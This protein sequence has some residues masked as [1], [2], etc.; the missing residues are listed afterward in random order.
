[1]FGCAAIAIFKRIATVSVNNSTEEWD[2]QTLAQK[3][4][5]ST[6][7]NITAEDVERMRQIALIKRHMDI[8]YGVMV[9]LLSVAGF[10]FV[11][12]PITI[13]VL[14]RFVGGFNFADLPR[15]QSIN[16][17]NY[18]LCCYQEKFAQ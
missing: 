3:N 8:Q 13:L 5:A 2:S 14:P 11:M 7:S 9:G 18:Y 1:V 6:Q 4:E 10:F 15:D 17:A 16:S 12:I